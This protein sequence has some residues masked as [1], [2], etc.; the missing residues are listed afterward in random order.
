[1][2]YSDRFINAVTSIFKLNICR[3]HHL[4]EDH[5]KHDPTIRTNY[6]ARNIFSV[7]AGTIQM[8]V[9]NDDYLPPP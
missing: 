8:F 4:L 7:S 9:K 3:T 5:E 2:R 1:M 6:C